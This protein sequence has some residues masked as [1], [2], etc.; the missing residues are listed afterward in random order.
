VVLSIKI[1][2]KNTNLKFVSGIGNSIVL[3]IGGAY[4]L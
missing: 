1:C 3:P 4:F 2:L